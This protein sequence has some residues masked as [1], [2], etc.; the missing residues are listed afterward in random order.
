[1]LAQEVSMSKHISLRPLKP[2]EKQTLTARIRDLSLA[3][4]VHQ[5]YRVVEQVQRGYSLAETADRVGCHFT[6]AYDWVHRF[7]ESGF[8]TFEEVANPKGRPPILRAAVAET[9]RS[10]SVKSAGAR[11]AVFQLVGTEVGRVLSREASAAGR[12]RRVGTT[13]AAPGRPYGT[14]DSDWKTS[15]DP[16]FDRKKL[17]QRLYRACPARSV[18]VCFDERG[19]L[20]V[21]PMGGLAWARTGRPVR[22]RA[23]YHR[24]HGIE[25]FLAFY[26]VHQDYLNGIF[27]SRRGV[28][29][30]S[31]AFRELRKCY[32][33]KR[34][35]AVLD[36]LHHVHDHPKFL[37]LLRK[38]HIHAA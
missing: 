15:S 3:A 2:G 36:N 11:S 7:N 27:R 4:R 24:L 5:R 30:V 8:T 16:Q 26:D 17:I 21:R 31:E 34:L 14:T 23:A 19:P 9:G 35:Y 6:V 28:E 20:E 10:R 38:L 18:I 33:R 22:M 37:A 32:P 1:M 29:E 12:Y 25:H 13:S